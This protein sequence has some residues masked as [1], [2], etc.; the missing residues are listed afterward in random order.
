MKYL[1]S[2]KKTEIYGKTCL[3]RLDFNI[4]DNDLKNSI[5]LKR[6]IPTILFL[7]ENKCKIV[8]LSHKGRPAGKLNIK[9]KKSKLSLKPVS[10]ALAK[11]LG[12][13]VKFIEHFG[14]KKIKKEIDISS[15]GS[16]FLLENLRFNKGEE[17]NNQLFARQLAL[18]GDF[19][20]N[21]AFAV[22]HRANAS[23]SKITKYLPSYCGFE[24]ESEIEVF[25]SVLKKP[26][27]PLILILGGAKISD[28]I[29]IIENFYNKVDSIL[30]GGGVANTFFVAR[31]IPIGSSLCDKKSIPLIKKYINDKKIIFP[32]DVIFDDKKAI[33]DIGSKT[34]VKY[35]QIISKA[36]TVV[37]N[38]PMGVIEKPKYQSGTL[39]VAKSISKSKAYSVIGGG[40]TTSF[41]VKNKLDDGISFVSIGGGAMLDYLAGYKMPGIESLK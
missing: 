20:V 29:G 19:Y 23:I 37:W 41:V 10:L 16:V 33:V 30:I 26:K 7:L 18:L 9:Y 39:G 4:Q 17:T 31:N 35:S 8:I 24:M 32:I 1:N 22:S 38:G 27:K 14:F 11:M 21:D 3:L 6:S 2:V 15:T 13:K 36:K 28:K 12:Q 25:N 5:R 40:E 34:I